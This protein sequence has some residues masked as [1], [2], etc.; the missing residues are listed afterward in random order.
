MLLPGAWN[1]IHDVLAMWA[2]ATEGE[3]IRLLVLDF[4][5][6]FYQLPL[7]PGERRYFCAKYKVECYLWA[8]VAQGSVNGPP[9]FG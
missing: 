1:V 3:D 2:K 5:D 8:R 7:I 4:Q 6:A 9:V